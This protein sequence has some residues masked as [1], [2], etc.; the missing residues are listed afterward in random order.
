LSF[1]RFIH[2]AVITHLFLVSLF[3]CPSFR[4]QELRPEQ[5]DIRS[6]ASV[7]LEHTTHPLAVAANDAGRVE[8]GKTLQRMVLVLAPTSDQAEQLRQFLDEQQNR[9]SKNYH[10]WLTP[11]EFAARFSPADSSVETVRNWLQQNGFTVGRVAAG[12]RWIEFNGTAQQVETALHTELHY[13]KYAGKNYLANANDVSLPASLAALSRGIVSLNNFPRRPPRQVIRGTAS[14]NARGQYVPLLPNL[15]ATGQSNT[16]YL[17]PGDFA[18]IYNTKPLLNG[19]TDGSGVSIA[20]TAQSD[21]ELT[22]VQTFRQIFQLKTND[23]N[24]F[25]S[26]PDP[27]FASATDSQEAMLDTEWAGAVA[28]GATINLVI[29][30]STDTTNGVDL[31]AAYAIDNEIAPIL[32]Y[33]YGSCEA[34]LGTS[35]NAFYNALWQQAA[36]EGITVL[37]AAGDNGTAGCD[38]ATEGTPATQGQAINGAAS[39]P[40]NVA[41]GGTQL[42]DEGNAANYWN[43]GNASDFSSAIGYIPE[44]AWNESCDPGQPSTPTNCVFG[45]GNFTLLAGAGGASTVYSKP[46]WQSGPGVP[47]DGARDVPDVAFASASDH[48]DIVYCNSLGGTPCQITGGNVVG[49]TLIGG[50]SASTPAMAGIL[51]LLEQKEG[52]YLGQIN[53][54]LYQLAKTNSCNSS[55]QTNP[56]AQTSCIFHDVTAGSNSVPC[57]GG[58]PGCS[59][60]QGGTNG[61]LTGQAATN[62]FDMATGLGSVNASNLVNAWSSAKPAASQIALHTSSA[63]FVHG[64]AITVS[65]TVAPASGTG[66]PTGDVSLKTDLYGDAGLLTLAAGAFTGSVNSL[67]GG[68]YN[69]FA[70]YA[71]DASFGPSDSGSVSLNVTPEASTTNLSLPELS[72]GSSPYGST[73][74]IKVNVIGSSGAGT[75]TGTI[76]VLDNS[77]VVGNYPLAADGV[78]Y[79]LTGAATAYSFAPGS[80]SLT[81]KYAGDNSFNASV[82]NA[83]AF[84]V[85]KSTPQVILGANTLNVNVGQ[86]VGVHA[87]VISNSGFT[88]NP[89]TGT[90]QFTDNG[91]PTLSPVTLQA[92][93]L[94]GTQSQ[95]SAILPN[96]PAGPHVIGAT[97]NASGDPNYTNVSSGDPQNEFMQTVTV[98]AS[99]GTQ[100]TT[101][102]N[103]TAPVNMGD[104]ATFSVTVSPSTAT[105]SVAVWDAVGLRGSPANISSGTATIHLPWTQ[106]GSTAVYAVYSGNAS[107]APSSSATI[108]FT[109]NKLTPQLV[110][111]AVPAG[112]SLNQQVSLNVTV[113]GRPSNTALPYPTGNVEFWDS[114][115]GGAPQLLST[116]MLTVGGGNVAV[117]ALRTKLALGSHSLHAHYRGDTNWLAADSATVAVTSSDFA[118]GVAPNPILVAGGSPGLATVT[119]TPSGG[120]TGM[121]TL[122]CPTGGTAPPVGYACAFSPSSSVN[123]TSGAVTATLNLTPSTS[124]ASAIKQTA[125]MQ[126]PEFLPSDATIFSGAGFNP[127]SLG[128]TRPKAF[129]IWDAGLVAIFAIFLLRFKPLRPAI[130]YFATAAT[131]GLI[132]IVVIG[133]GGGGSGGGGGGNQPV[134]STTSIVSSNLK[135][136]FQT[137]VS[138]TITVS[139]SSS[140]TGKVQLFDNGQV[141]GTAVTLNSGAAI[142]AADALPVGLHS[143]TARYQG[144]TNTLPSTSPVISQVITGT[145]N[146]QISASSQSTSHMASFNVT[147]D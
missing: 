10:Q 91:V 133:C 131:V 21:I 120:F 117:F 43:A 64:T 134:P 122:T 126:G 94:F 92:G 38:N 113:A 136:S 9:S 119:I 22:D 25:F 65:G 28:P 49:L 73:L 48:D 32:T 12:K 45:N 87:V 75:A 54:T 88:A 37:V 104:T 93:G 19:G 147:V 5:R 27:G 101:Q 15:T 129:I 85:G 83:V 39:T 53:Y 137:P 108:P 14:R 118:V 7:R 11:Q 58:T 46:T 13:Y 125:L 1:P 29:A 79:I 100:T 52:P 44:E 109:V 116:Q 26:G 31:A 42:Q 63:S 132:I 112:A 47:A 114:L 102:L 96:L 67:P 55:A 105:G 56:T 115:N 41:V 141:L 60:T 62:G 80:H 81:A 8:A 140:P 76:T 2:L 103:V 69:F 123:V 97:Y 23:P 18:A 61:I 139:A 36:A 135:A 24:I 51:A 86:S 107:D 16:Y 20:V 127:A 98:G 95:A 121:V 50:T 143:L 89:A 77:T 142:F 144:D 128:V 106:A 4:A 82:S 57:A 3:C 70:H 130:R 146:M 71:G 6:E 74:H 33:T 59:S 111:L 84:T 17:A 68:Q 90:I 35:G 78:A 34:A 72:G 66:S 145:V 124:A 138:F 30:G 99:K 110:Q 40:Y